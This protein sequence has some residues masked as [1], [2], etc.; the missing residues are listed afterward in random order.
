MGYAGRL[1][2]Y[3]LLSMC[4]RDQTT[5]Q[6]IK[7]FQQ[8]FSLFGKPVKFKSDGN[9]QFDGKEMRALFEE[10]CI[11]H[12]KSCPYNPQSNGHAERNVGIVKQ[13][14]LKTNKDIHS[15]QFLD[16]IPQIRNIPRVAGCSS[17]QIVF[18][19]SIR[20]LIPTLSKALGTNEFFE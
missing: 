11:Q 10:Y 15:K 3:P 6:V 4:T 2:G 12:G 19:R 20:T 13:L 8:Y 16:G 7:P 18:G 5:G 9:A 17:C 1:S 14:I